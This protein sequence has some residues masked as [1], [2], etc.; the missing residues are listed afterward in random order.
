MLERQPEVGVGDRT[1]LGDFRVRSG[2]DEWTFVEVAA[3]DA[4]IGE[5][6]LNRM[7]EQLAS[8]IDQLR[9]PYALDVVLRREPTDAETAYLVQRIREL[10][11]L[12]LAVEDDL[13]NGLGKL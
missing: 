7:R 13:P 1:R 9:R 11:R 2:G 4:S 8:L 12:D 10:C 6:R 5:E 3:P